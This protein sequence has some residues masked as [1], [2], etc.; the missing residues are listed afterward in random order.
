MS[1][2]FL[3]SVETANTDISVQIIAEGADHSSRG[4]IF[5][6]KIFFMGMRFFE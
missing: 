4:T 1:S 5:V 3:L 6:L 2:W